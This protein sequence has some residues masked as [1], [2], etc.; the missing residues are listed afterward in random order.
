[1]EIASVE[2][3]KELVKLNL[4]VSV[5][6]PWAVG[7]DLGRGSLR[8]RPVGPQPLRR[9]WVIASLAGRRLSLVEETFCRLCRNHAAGM[10]LDRRDVPS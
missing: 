10:P 5:L 2:A 7:K 4:G 1:M 6:A 9:Q 8:M 3:I